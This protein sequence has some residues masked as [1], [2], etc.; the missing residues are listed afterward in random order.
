MGADPMPS[1]EKARARI[2]EL[3]RRLAVLDQERADVVAELEEATRLLS[4]ATGD[5]CE[6][7][8]ISPQDAPVTMAS[9]TAAEV[10]LFHSLFRG[11]EDVFPR[12][13]ENQK[14]GKSGYSP[15]C[16]NEWLRGVCGKPEIIPVPLFSDC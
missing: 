7:H 6:N 9:P 1:Q 11:R 2:E 12:R 3:E 14:T 13:W 15:V 4:A 16:R 10:A 8:A 5:E